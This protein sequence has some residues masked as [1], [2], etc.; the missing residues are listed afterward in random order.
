RTSAGWRSAIQPRVKNVAETPAPAN[1]SRIRAQLSST[2][3]ARPS[4]SSRAITRSKAPT[5]NH[6]STSTERALT[7]GMKGPFPARS[8]RGL[9]IALQPFN[10][11]GKRVLNAGFLLDHARLER[12]EPV[13]HAA[14]TLVE[15]GQIGL[16]P[17]VGENRRGLAFEGVG[18][19]DHGL[20][21]LGNE[22]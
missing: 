12:T 17:A 7:T 8:G 11:H 20:L 19:L 18:Q 9:L 1:R 14:Q 15:R 3:E 4:H 10:Q 2:R 21:Q 13:G 22:D 6:S 16:D 5:W